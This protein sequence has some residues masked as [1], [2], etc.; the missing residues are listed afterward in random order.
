[1]SAPVHAFQ[2]FYNPATRAALDPGFEPLDNLSNERPEWCEYWPMRRFFAGHALDE[3]SYYGFFS[4]AFGNKTGIRAAELKDFVGQAGDADVVTF[5]PYLDSSALF[6]NVFEQGATL[7]EGLLE[8]ATA[9]A[10]EVDPRLRLDTLVQDTRTTVYSNFFVAKAAFWREWQRIFTL[11]FDAAETP[12]SALHGLLNRPIRY[13]DVLG[14]RR[15][16]DVKIMV[17]ERLPSL[18]LSSGRFRVRNYKPFDLPLHGAIAGYL[19]QLIALDAL[20]VA[21]LQTGERDFLLQFRTSRDQL[22]AVIAP[23]LRIFR[24]KS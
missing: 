12:G 4:P 6:Q 14:R 17:L 21:Y 8:A 20:K 2:I 10:H 22:F 9:V 15:P 11:C 13:T 19:P 23:I 18:L 3:S 1:M 16:M 7:F 5:S 24:F